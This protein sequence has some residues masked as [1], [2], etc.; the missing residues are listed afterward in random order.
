VWKTVGAN[1]K[2][3]HD[4][5]LWSLHQNLNNISAYEKENIKVKVRKK[6][7]E[8]FDEK[9]HFFRNFETGGLH[10][11]NDDGNTALHLMVICNHVEAFRSMIQRRDD[12][13]A[14][15]LKNNNGDTALHLA[16]I[17][18]RLEMTRILVEAG[19]DQKIKNGHGKTA[20][21]HAI[22]HR[23]L[24]IVALLW[25]ERESLIGVR[26]LA[27]IHMH[28]VACK[29]FFLGLICAILIPKFFSWVNT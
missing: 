17:K 16:A 2:P 14:L 6:N 11:E 26:Q 23:N 19:A 13:L 27:L 22:H 5:K 21:R 12:N 1:L 25:D 24:Q 4:K 10:V 29:F 28:G 15:N 9:W 18:N 20:L 8:K 7:Q 3:T